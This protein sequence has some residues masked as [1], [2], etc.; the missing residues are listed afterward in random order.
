MAMDKVLQELKARTGVQSNARALKNAPSNLVIGPLSDRRSDDP[1]ANFDPNI[2]SG[3]MTPRSQELSHVDEMIK[4]SNINFDTAARRLE[5][6]QELHGISAPID[7]PDP[8]LWEKHGDK[9]RRR[10]SDE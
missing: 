6:A 5:R 2:K 4:S 1:G 9:F 3:Q 8:T 10:T 7:L